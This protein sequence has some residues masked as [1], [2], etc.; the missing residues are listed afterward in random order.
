MVMNIEYKIKEILT[1]L[2]EKNG[3]TDASLSRATGVSPSSIARIRTDAKANPTINVI[4]PI[5]K[6]YKVSIDQLLG[7]KPIYDGITSINEGENSI[8]ARIVPILNKDLIKLWLQE[9][10]EKK[11]ISEWVRS[12]VKDLKCY[13][14][15]CK[16]FTINI[17]FNDKSVMV[18]SP[19]VNPSPGDSIIISNKEFKTP[20]LFD[21]H[22]KNGEYFI[23][24]IDKPGK[25]FP[26]KLPFNFYG[27]VSEIF[28]H[29]HE[30]RDTNLIRDGVILAPFMLKCT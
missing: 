7:K 26:L 2:M 29:T 8:Y 22:I 6:Y 3:D 30:I 10:I 25:L 1:I 24:K 23:S 9:K 19:L 21:L 27:V 28:Y 5:A 11:S 12:S 14:I 20:S 18:I 4:I 13:A 15:K 16:D 17:K